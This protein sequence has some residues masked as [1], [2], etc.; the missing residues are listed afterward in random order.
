M[1]L[2]DKECENVILNR[3]TKTKKMNK[4]NISHTLHLLGKDP[5]KWNKKCFGKV[6]EVIKETRNTL[7][8]AKKKDVNFH[9]I[10]VEM[11]LSKKLDEYLVRE[12]ELWRQKSRE[13]WL[14]RWRPKYKVFS[15]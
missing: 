8:M 4:E 15:C 10:E 2:R 13:I 1:W 12:E 6:E 3:L 14:K 11:N 9:S 5:T 7:E